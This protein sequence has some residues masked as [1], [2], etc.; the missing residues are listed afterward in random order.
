MGK[1]VGKRRAAGRALLPARPGGQERCHGC[2]LV[3][4]FQEA[5]YLLVGGVR[6][7]FCR[8]CAEASDPAGYVALLWAEFDAILAE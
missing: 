4:P 3:M 1:S 2:G 8:P 6:S 7:V 5:T